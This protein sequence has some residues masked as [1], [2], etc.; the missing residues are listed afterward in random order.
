MSAP[1]PPPTAIL[2]IYNPI[3]YQ[4]NTQILDLETAESIFYKKSGGVVS[5][6]ASFSQGLNS[7]GQVN[8]T[9]TTNSTNRVSGALVVAGGL[10]VDLDT[11]MNNL[12]LNASTS[13]CKISGNNGHILINNNTSAS[14]S[15][16]TGAVRVAGGAYFGANSI[17]NTNLQV[18][19]LRIG[20]ATGTL[21]TTLIS[22]TTNVA[23]GQLNPGDI[24]TT[25]NISFG[26]TFSSTPR[27]IINIDGNADYYFVQAW[28]RDITTTNFKVIFRNQASFSTGANPN[29][30]V[31][32]IA[33]I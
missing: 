15:I 25:A 1:Y 17:F 11:H 31:F 12:H 5:G 30:N 14:T 24:F 10:G 8:I 3:N 2:S 21:I 18:G 23:T 16:S 20:G 33:F 27:V 9:N 32:W 13:E 6:L 7:V 26:I 19:G 22:G 29:T 28:P 4:L